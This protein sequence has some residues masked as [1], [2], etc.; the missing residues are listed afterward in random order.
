MI[1]RALILAGGE[2]LRLRPHTDDVPKA[3]VV[4]AG[5]P[6]I[7]WIIDWLKSNNITKIDI[8]VDYK[9]EVLMD[10]LKDG[11]SLG[12]EIRYNDHHGA[13]GTGD[14][15]RRAIENLKI[16]DENFIAMNGDELTDLPIKS[17]YNY[18]REHQPIVTI[19]TSQVQLPF[20]VV[21]TE[22]DGKIVTFREKPVLKEHVNM[23]VYI[24]NKEVI[25]HLPE[26]GNIEHTTFP[27]L[28][29]IGKIRAFRYSGFWRT[30]NDIKDLKITE[31]RLKNL[32]YKLN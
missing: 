10:Y 2:A 6:I 18:H 21:E 11:K 13:E 1:Q 29:K 17:L 12:V 25:N 26:K 14:A 15:L 7:H 9:K 24:F 22:P 28:A 16:E 23:G 30:I 4:V 32:D 3:M 8:G 31:E 27:E 19:V 5:K 20:G